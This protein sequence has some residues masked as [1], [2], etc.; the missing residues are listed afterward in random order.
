MRSVRRAGVVAIAPPCAAPA[1]IAALE[2]RQQRIAVGADETKVVEV[3]VGRVSV[4]VVH[5]QRNRM[6]VP[7]FRMA[8]CAPAASTQEISTQCARRESE[9]GAGFDR[10]FGTQPARVGRALRTAVALVRRLGAAGLA[11]S[12]R[13]RGTISIPVSRSALTR[14]V[15]VRALG[16][17]ELDAAIDVAAVLRGSP[18]LQEPSKR[19]YVV[20]HADRAGSRAVRSCHV[21]E[22]T[23][24]GGVPTEANAW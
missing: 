20:S 24:A 3:V 11:R 9:A 23:G 17:R 6:A 8:D 22:R 7:D 13:R 12:N 4:H 19:S 10:P 2:G 16:P 18:V 5:H 1:A 14:A 15:V 21:S